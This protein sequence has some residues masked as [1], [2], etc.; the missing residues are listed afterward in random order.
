MQKVLFFITVPGKIQAIISFMKRTILLLLL[1][2]AATVMYSQ[3]IQFEPLTW[4][5]ALAKARKEKKMIF[6]DVYTTW[7]TYCRQMDQ[8]I[9]PLAEVGSF[10]NEHFINLKIDALKSDGVAIRKNYRLLGFPT[11]LYLDT[12]GMLIKRTAGYQDKNIFIQYGMEAFAAI[13]GH[14]TK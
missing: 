2:L 8:Q 1:L 9:F 7:C 13:K 5:Q 4:M 12:D 14:Q 3:Q 11:F 6:I 10:Y